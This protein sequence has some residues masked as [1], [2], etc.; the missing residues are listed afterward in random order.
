MNVTVEREKE[1]KSQRALELDELR[2][3]GVAS[4]RKTKLEDCKSSVRENCMLY[5]IF[6]Y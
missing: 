1:I 6:L 2:S 4:V 5:I 3:K